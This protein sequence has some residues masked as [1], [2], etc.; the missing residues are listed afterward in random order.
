MNFLYMNDSETMM[1]PS[2]AMP[3]QHLSASIGSDTVV[4]IGWH[5]GQAYPK[6]Y[7]FTIEDRLACFAYPEN[8]VDEGVSYRQDYDILIGPMPGDWFTAATRYRDWAH[9][10]FWCGAGRRRVGPSSRRR[11]CWKC[12]SGRVRVG[13]GTR[14]ARR[15]QV[16]MPK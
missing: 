2:G 8:M 11:I 6:G 7:N 5:D 10:Q 9:R 12:P 3:I 14:K 1:W 4:Y 13:A 15:I 16:R